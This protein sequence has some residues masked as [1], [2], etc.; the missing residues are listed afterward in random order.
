MRY[1]EV[2]RKLRSLGCVNLSHKGTGSH[3]KWYNPAAKNTVPVPIPDWG[4]RDLKN[5]TLRAI[6]RQL[7]LA[8]EDFN[9]V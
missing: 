3:R 8:W 4:S 9:R 7:E 6:V 2:E 5:G 1:R